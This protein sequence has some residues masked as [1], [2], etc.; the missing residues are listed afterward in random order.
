MPVTTCTAALLVGAHTWTCTRSGVHEL[1]AG[2]DPSGRWREWGPNG[3]RE[4]TPGHAVLKWAIVHGTMT[5][6]SHRS[7]Q[8][9]AD[10][11]WHAQQ[12][13]DES[14]CGIEVIEHGASRML[15][16]VEVDALQQHFLDDE[17]AEEAAAAAQ[18]DRPFLIM[19][20]HPTR[21]EFR[22]PAWAVYARHRLLEDAVAAAAELGVDPARVRIE[23]AHTRHVWDAAG[24]SR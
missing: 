2:P 19:L 15:T 4:I 16:N 23:H 21:R 18:P 8:D 24:V 17:A 12:A 13:G 10:D 7:A 6:T 20:G 22:A 5:C 9:A 14:F 1:H 3:Y 11:A